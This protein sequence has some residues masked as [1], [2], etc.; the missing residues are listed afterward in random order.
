ML[1]YPSSN[2][3]LPLILVEGLCMHV[4]YIKKIYTAN[5]F[6]H[7]MIY[8]MWLAWQATKRV[9]RL[10]DSN[11]F[12]C[13][14]ITGVTKIIFA[15]QGTKHP[16][17]FYVQVTLS[18]IFCVVCSENVTRVTQM[19]NSRDIVAHCTQIHTCIWNLTKQIIIFK[20]KTLE[21]LNNLTIF[22]VWPSYTQ[23]WLRSLTFDH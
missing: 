12:S 8:L 6:K 21:D 17:P 14:P 1:S 5:T 15:E 13:K 2:F 20:C 4:L 10:H 11:G 9:L 22:N 3:N 19:W 7:I 16:I 18:L 23:N